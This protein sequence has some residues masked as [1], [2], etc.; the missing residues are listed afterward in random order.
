MYV[1]DDFDLIHVSKLTARKVK[2]AAQTA[3]QPKA[4]AAAQEGP[5]PKGSLKA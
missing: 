2:F 1:V 4:P 3:T 5:F